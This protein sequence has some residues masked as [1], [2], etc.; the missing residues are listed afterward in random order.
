MLTSFRHTSM[1]DRTFDF[2]RLRHMNMSR[3]EVMN[4]IRVRWRDLEGDQPRLCCPGRMTRDR[5][6]RT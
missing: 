2:D 5:E 3:D 4:D 1:V 6:G